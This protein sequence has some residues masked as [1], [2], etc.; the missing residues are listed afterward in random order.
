MLALIQQVSA[1]VID[2]RFRALADAEVREK[3]PGDLVTAADTEAEALLT[4]ALLDA[5]PGAVVLG[6]EASAAGGDLLARFTAAEHTF[7]IDPV[8][9]TKNFVEGSPDHAVMVAELRGSEVVRSWIWQPQHR[10][11]YVAERGA[12]AF[13]DGERLGP[14]DRAAEPTAWHGVTSARRRLGRPLAP[15][16][17][18]LELTWVCCGVDYPQVAQGGADYVV[19]TRANPWDHAPGQLLLSESGGVLAWA[20]GERYDARRVGERTDT[21]PLLAAGS[22]EVHAELVR[23]LAAGDDVVR[24]RTR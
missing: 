6:E 21:L 20:S 2:P 5:Y 9:G 14:A 16:L 7:T 10:T 13:R 3:G 4:L 24:H 1:E 18:P 11:A 12:G 17:P 23:R 19:Y 22:G 15:G 8:D